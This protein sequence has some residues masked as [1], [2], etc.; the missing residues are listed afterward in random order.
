M[1]LTRKDWIILSEP[2]ISIITP[3][4]NQCNYIEDTI[5]SVLGQT[6]VDL[7]YIIMDGGS[8]DNTLDVINRYKND[9]RLLFYSEQDKGQ[10]DAVNRGFLRASG[11]ILGW[12]NADDI[13]VKDALEKISAVFHKSPDA[14]IVYGRLYSFKTG[15][16]TRRRMFCRDFSYKW[17]RRYCYTNPSVTFIRKSVIEQDGFLIDPSVSTYGDWD[18]YLRM[19][20]NGKKFRYLSETLGYFRIH[21]F[22]RI[23]RMDQRQSR[24]ERKMIEQ[25]HGIPLSY[26]SL[27]V[28]NIIPWTERF[29]NFFLLLRQNKWQ[30]I[31]ARFASASGV[32]CRDLWHR[33]I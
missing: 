10:Y 33:F 29:D 21:E 15:E 9:P 5:L 6:F 24:L 31:A 26:M 30:E 7:E 14:E 19:A 2:R 27:W 22:S 3:S 32:V 4:L 12:I 28:D 1:L 13:Y 23:M 25:R 18:W 8:T 11:D 20:K 17:L 16:K